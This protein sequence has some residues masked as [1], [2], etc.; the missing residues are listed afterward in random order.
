M[1]G[2]INRS[3]ECFV[4]DT[5][6]AETWAS[7]AQAADLGFAG[8]EALLSY[9][10]DVTESVLNA[11]SD[12]LAMPRE[13]VLEDLGTYLVSAPRMEAVRRLL[14]LGGEDYVEFLFSLDDLRDRARFAMADLELP[15][16][17]LRDHTD[18]AFT[19]FV[20]HDQVGFGFVL[21]GVLRAM[22]DDYGVLAL[23]EH[24]G[25]RDLIETIEIEL[26]QT[27]FSE[28]RDFALAVST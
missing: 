28:G 3:V 24:T 14:R 22:A 17:E 4:S 27:D 16:L 2:L 18:K 20:H 26:I 8:F 11:A 1:H 12:K 23:M 19:I 13:M 15:R 7:V 6:G 10:P 25:R 5:Y 9:D 21:L